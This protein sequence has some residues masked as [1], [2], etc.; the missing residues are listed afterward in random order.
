MRRAAAEVTSVKNAMARH[1]GFSP[2]QWVLGK[3]PRGPGDQ[4]DEQEYSDMGVIQSK[5][6]PDSIFAETM[7]ARVA[8]RK[9]SVKED[10]S[11]RVSRAILRKAAP[12]PGKYNVGDLV[13]FRREQ[14]NDGTQRWSTA[15]RVIGHDGPKTIWVVNEGVPV[16]VSVDRLR[17]C[18][19]PESLAYLHTNGP[20]PRPVF[21]SG[22][23]DV[24]QRYVGF[25]P[26][27][28]T[29]R[30]DPDESEHEEE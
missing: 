13:V 6:D 1:G 4:L 30:R 25:Q 21:Q 11:R 5:F 22:A 26:E 8:A 18:T 17:P 28:S 23:P 24:Q 15:S 27:S 3:T 19:P 20:G 10:C 9:A 14:G 2:S 12:L 7:A 29:Q 16:C